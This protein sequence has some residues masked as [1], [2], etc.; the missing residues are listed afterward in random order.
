[1]DKKDVDLPLPITMGGKKSSLLLKD[2]RRK[3][4]PGHV[5]VRRI[6][7]RLSLEWPFAALLG[8]CAASLGWWWLTPATVE[9]PH[10][11]DE[12]LLVR[13]MAN[14][15]GQKSAMKLELPMP[16][17]HAF[18]SGDLLMLP[19][20][21]FGHP[22]EVAVIAEE[23]VVEEQGFALV[24]AGPEALLGHFD[25]ARP[26]V[27]I[28]LVDY[29]PETEGPPIVG[30]T[31]EADRAVVDPIPKAQADDEPTQPVLYEAD[32][33]ITID[34]DSAEEMSDARIS[35][36]D[37]IIPRLTEKLR[38]PGA[39]TRFGVTI[40]PGTGLKGKTEILNTSAARLDRQ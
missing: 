28:E 3:I 34:T 40:R 16:K 13:V 32:D 9:L 18:D 33:C 2:G 35:T 27:E 12:V 1:M 7:A 21:Q 23:S 8:S 24:N 20:V 17:R 39:R 11:D 30:I 10:A 36:S 6:Q 29:Q 4:S 26:D 5:W 19:E 31:L 22:T 25:D 15:P 37:E 14:R 38:P